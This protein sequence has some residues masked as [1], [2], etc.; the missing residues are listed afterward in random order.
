MGLVK[1]TKRA[2]LQN[3]VT[4]VAHRRENPYLSVPSSLEFHLYILFPDVKKITAEK[5]GA[6]TTLE[7][8]LKGGGKEARSALYG[9]S[10]LHTRRP[11][12][13]HI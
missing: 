3:P 1:V 8:K 2:Q 9:K 11:T 6:L 13:Y 7:K 12:I 4:H 10:H 5:N